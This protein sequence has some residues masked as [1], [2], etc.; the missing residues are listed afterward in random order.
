MALPSPA[1][2][3]PRL[4]VRAAAP[5]LK[6]VFI[7]GTPVARFTLGVRVNPAARI[8]VI[9]VIGFMFFSSGG[10]A[11]NQDAI[12]GATRE[13]GPA[14]QVSSDPVSSLTGDNSPSA[15]TDGS[16]RVHDDATVDLYGN[17]VTSAVAQY[18]LD[19]GGS[20]YETH[21]PRTELPRLGPPKS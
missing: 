19:S 7:R 1:I 14:M 12:R 20:L 5:Q 10:P 13:H 11:R 2:G 15:D 17:E 16:A 9:A 21:S 3:A 8:T 4:S 6:S 18:K